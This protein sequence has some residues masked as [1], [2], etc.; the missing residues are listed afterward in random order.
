MDFLSSLLPSIEHFKT[1]A[2]LAVFWI[3]FLESL[4]FVG[5]IMPGSTLIIVAGFL[6]SQGYLS[7]GVLVWVTA[8][9]AIFGD[10]LSYYL[11]KR[12]TGFFQENHR[13]FKKKYLDMGESFFKKHGDKSVFLA[14]FI[15]PIR[16]IVPFV[17]GVSKMNH[18]EFLAFNISSAILW[19]FSYLLVGYFFGGAFESVKGILPVA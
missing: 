19:S 13:I 17:A 16:P 2:Y 9:G 10:G 6:T 5:L 12:G 1:L 14:R 3:A 7:F 4:A 15:G 8:L 18:W 11:G